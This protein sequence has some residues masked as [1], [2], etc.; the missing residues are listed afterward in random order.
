LKK[1]IVFLLLIFLIIFRY[2]TTRPVYKNGD[3][4]RI[5]ATVYSDP[6]DYTTSQGVKVGGLTAYLPSFPEINYGDK[7]IV[8]GTINNGKLDNPKLI[9]DVESQSFGSGVRNK[10]VDFY[11]SVLPQP[12]SGAIAGVTLGDRGAI[13]S[14]FWQKIKSTGVVYMVSASGVKIALLISFLV[15]A[16]TYILPRRKAIP[17]VILGTILY[18][19]IAGFSASIARGAIMALLVF[20]GQESGRLVSRW[21]ILAITASLMLIVQPDWVTD[22]G[23]ILSFVALA[24]IMLF[25]KR[26]E[27]LLKFLPKFL[28]EELAVS[29]AAQIGM[30]PILFV[31]FGQF[32]IWS[33]VVNVITLWTVPYIMILGSGGGIIGLVFPILGKLILWFSYPLLWWFVKVIGIFS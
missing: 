31:T 11:E 27:K 14:D 12:F 25:A 33:P 6:I 29:L 16:L 10:I 18:I 7:I 17:F 26:I 1:Y 22:I 13:M 15:G 4:V 24:S 3:S 21:R 8:E 5:T 32:N 19:F 9:S 28:K 23:F 30:F 20:L 2:F